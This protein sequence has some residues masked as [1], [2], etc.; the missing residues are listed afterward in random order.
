MSHHK[1]RRGVA[2][3]IVGL[4]ALLVGSPG[5]RAAGLTAV[6]GAYHVEA[7]T[8]PS[9]IPV[10]RAAVIVRISDGAGKEVAGAHVRVLAQMPGM[11]MGERT[12]E[13]QPVAGKP[14]YYQVPANFQMAGDWDVTVEIDGAQGQ[15]RAVLHAATGMQTGGGGIGRGFLYPALA[16][17][18]GLLLLLPLVLAARNPA[19]RQRMRESIKRSVNRTTIGGVLLLAAIYLAGR[20]AVAHYRRPGAMSVIEA[21]AM[22]MTVMKPPVGATPVAVAPV[23]RG[24]LDATVRYTGSV[25]PFGEQDVSPRVTGWIR[26]MPFY[27]G[28]RVRK[29]QLLARLDAD[30]LQSRVGE[31]LA[32]RTMAEHAHRIAQEGARQARA[33][34]AAVVGTLAEARQQQA[35]AKAMVKQATE[36]VSQAQQEQVA[37]REERVQAEAELAAAQS[38]LADAEAGVSAARADQEYWRAEIQRMGQLLKSGAVSGEEYQREKA[39]AE[40]AEAKVRQADAKRQQGQAGVQTAQSKLRK[41]DAMI[42]AAGA[43][44]S[45]AA[46]GVEQAQ[47]DAGAAAAKVT[48]V[49]AEIRAS[50]AAAEAA[51]HQIEHTAAGVQE[52]QA[53]LN[54]A[55]VV[56]NYTEIRSEV[57]GVITE[58][59]ISPG[60]LVS[61]GT[62][63]LKIAQIQPIRLQ[64]N[65]A[66]GDLAMVRGGNHV[67]ARI[68]RDRGRLVE[69]RV[70][71]VFPAADP[72]ARTGLVEAVVPNADGRLRPGEYVSMEIATAQRRNTLLVPA[73]AVT[74]VA[75]RSD[76]VLALAE[77]PAV[78]TMVAGA[79]GKPVYTCTMHPN[80]KQDKPGKCPT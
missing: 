62:A 69:A 64:A 58:R 37:A 31:R 28:D 67:R 15:G 35:R 13:A 42:A 4:I 5:V 1:R 36:G 11:A 61:P 79:A 63:I 12:E 34:A 7:T 21:Q 57:D 32:G 22:D 47:A 55:S 10:G 45:A 9:P 52:A 33:Q 41:A 50:E 30:E 66:E 40:N 16:L 65:V 26:W 3:A 23:K 2:G 24:S 6:A 59:L 60:T 51:A 76:D 72:V 74:Q 8:E 75:Q 49:A 25:V 53:M 56:Q 38:S 80:V 43:R 17:L 27:A 46:A 68:A 14:G 18:A 73:A 71:S 77:A 29:G 44:V 48:Q 70:T 54:T 19:T 20:Y 78:W 39:Q